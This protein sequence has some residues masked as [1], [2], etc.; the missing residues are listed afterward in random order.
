MKRTI[1]LSLFAALFTLFINAQ[2]TNNQ[3]V[4]KWKYNQTSSLTDAGPSLETMYEF[5][6]D[7]N[8]V[9]VNPN[10]EIKGT[11][12]YNSSDKTLSLSSGNK[13]LSKFSI[14]ELSAQKM[15]MQKGKKSLELVKTSGNYTA[16]AEKKIN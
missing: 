5:T 3:L 15:T 6:A 16:P 1:T 4:G 8:F 12:S 13:I 11:W 14:T 2:D 7:G 9:V 10:G